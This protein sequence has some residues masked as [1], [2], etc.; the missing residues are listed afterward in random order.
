MEYIEQFQVFKGNNYELNMRVSNKSLSSGQMQKVSF[1]RAL[2][3]KPDL[4]ILD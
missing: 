3:S 1:I 4:L 2:L